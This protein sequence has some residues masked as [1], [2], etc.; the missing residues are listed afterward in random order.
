MKVRMIE[1]MMKRHYMSLTVVEFYRRRHDTISDFVVHAKRANLT[2]T[3]E[4]E[5]KMWRQVGV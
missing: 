5:A 3:D 1:N 2:K 4:A